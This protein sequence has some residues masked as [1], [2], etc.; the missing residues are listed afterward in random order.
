MI[1][2]EAGGR[3]NHAIYKKFDIERG[4]KS[5]RLISQTELPTEV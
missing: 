3:I 4:V 1:R 5:I 2:D